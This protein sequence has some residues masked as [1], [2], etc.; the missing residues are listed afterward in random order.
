M[1][2]LNNRKILITGVKAQLGYY[3]Q[4]IL[5]AMPVSVTGLSRAD[6]DVCDYDR[7]KDVI[8]QIKPDILINCAAD[9]FIDRA[10]DDSRSAYAVNSTAVEQMATICRRGGIFLVHYSTAHVFD[11]F[12]REH[13]LETDEPNPLNVYGRSKLQGDQAIQS[14]LDRYLILRL[15]WVFGQGKNCFL[16]KVERWAETQAVINISEDEISIP[17]YAENVVDLTLQCLLKGMEG[18][19]H[20]TSSGQCSR[21]QYVKYYF[22]R[23][24]NKTQINPQ[25]LDSF[26]MKAKRPMF[27][28]MSND[29]ISK[30]LKQP[31]DDWTV[32][33]EQ[34]IK[35]IKHTGP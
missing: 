32:G 25:P 7:L 17:T 11:G 31:I 22:E 13:Y 4:K 16:T 8:A 34:F 21:Y 33:L 9:N 14:I 27:S 23:I 6:L 28:C 1:D 24:K 18:L 29:K 15:S 5:A 19:Y 12:K 2:R 3:F 20:L 10:E 30:C 26:H 35:Q